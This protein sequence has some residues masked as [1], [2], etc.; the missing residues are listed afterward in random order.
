MYSE[1]VQGPNHFRWGQWCSNLRRSWFLFGFRLW[2]ELHITKNRLQIWYASPVTYVFISHP[3][4]FQDPNSL[5]DN[6]TPVQIPEVI[7]KWLTDALVLHIVAF[8]LAAISALFGLLAHIREFATVYCSTFISGLAASV[9]LIAFIFDIAFF[10]LTKSRINSIK[11]ASA[12]TGNAIWLTL[13]AFLLLFFAGCFYSIG[14]CCIIGRPRGPRIRDVPSDIDSQRAEALRLDA[15]KAESDR[16]ARQKQKEMGLPAFPEYDSRK[17]L[18]LEDDEYYQD[19]QPSPRNNSNFSSGY[20]N[21]STNPMPN[22][23]PAA[24]GTAARDAYYASSATANA[25]ATYPPPPRQTTPQQQT[26]YPQAYA[27]VNSQNAIPSP[28]DSYNPNVATLAQNQPASSQYASGGQG[29][30]QYSSA[31]HNQYPSSS[32]TQYPSA[33]SDPYATTG[34]GQSYSQYSSN[35][36]PG[37]YGYDQYDPN[38]YFVPSA[39]NNQRRECLSF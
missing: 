33:V 2:R 19:N 4:R 21:Q 24:K 14:R 36:V 34:H 17:P 8:V 37:S 23:V 5:L 25:A 3:I 32:H 18:T 31:I 12:Q 6:T 10:F 35:E 7:V 13:A 20:F 30:T 38:S 9:A 1:L 22:Y 11:G 39:D 29:Q 15:V 26:S 27:G 16:K 28:Y